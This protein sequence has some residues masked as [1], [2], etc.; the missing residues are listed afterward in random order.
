[1]AVAQ[2][3]LDVGVGLIVTEQNVEARLALLDEVVF[4]RERFPLVCD[5]NVL[6]IDGLAHEGT[7]FCVGLVGGKKI[8]PHA[9]AQVFCLSDVDHL[10]FG[11]LVEVTAGAGR[12]CA[13]FVVQIHGKLPSTW[14]ARSRLDVCG[15]GAMQSR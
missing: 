14:T 6:E 12:E 10:A 1:M 4:Q 2:R 5:E 11:V 13:Y 15:S 3:E 9:R 8:G 7:G